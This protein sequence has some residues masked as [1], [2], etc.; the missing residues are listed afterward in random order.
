MSSVASHGFT[1]AR[2]P[3]TVRVRTC[4]TF[5]N[6]QTFTCSFLPFFLSSFLLFFF[7]STPPTP[8]GGIL[9]PPFT[10]LLA[11][12]SKSYFAVGRPRNL[13]F[14]IPIFASMFDDMLLTVEPPKL[15]KSIS[16]QPKWLP[17]SIPKS[18][19]N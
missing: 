14:R 4:T 8:Q 17:K 9:P 1:Y 10:S 13:L 6:F 3:P 16:N 7:S 18:S 12:S 2:N 5:F 19:E 11:T 15:Q